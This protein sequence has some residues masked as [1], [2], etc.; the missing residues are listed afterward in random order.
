LDPASVPPASPTPTPTPFP[1]PAPSPLFDKKECPGDVDYPFVGWTTTDALNI[2]T[3]FNG[4]VFA[5]VTA[6]VI[7][8][9]EWV[10]PPSAPGLT[11]RWWDRGSA[12][13]RTSRSA[14]P[15]TTSSCRTQPS[16]A[17]GSRSG[18]TAGTSRGIR[19]KEERLSLRGGS[20]PAPAGAPA[21]AQRRQ[22]HF[23]SVKRATARPGSL[24]RCR[25]PKQPAVTQ[26]NHQPWSEWSSTIGC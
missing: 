11:F 5:M 14:S 4:Y 7:P 25:L 2:D 17:P 16:T 12:T 13:P 21:R 6:H 18:R 26:R 10:D 22:R 23:C 19:P 20:E 9:G 24:S 15:R 8:I 3:Q 1:S